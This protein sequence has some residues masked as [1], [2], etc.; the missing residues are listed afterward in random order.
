MTIKHLKYRFDSA[1]VLSKQLSTT[2]SQLITLVVIRAC[3]AFEIISVSTTQSIV[4]A[5]FLCP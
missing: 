5:S 2:Q 1:H 3:K 4:F